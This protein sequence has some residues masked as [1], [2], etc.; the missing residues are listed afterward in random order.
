MTNTRQQS[1][2]YSMCVSVNMCNG[3]GVRSIVSVCVCVCV[4]FF[5]LVFHVYPCVYVCICVSVL[6]VFPIPMF[7]F[8]FYF[9]VSFP[10]CF[11]SSLPVC[12]FLHQSSCVP[13]V[14]N[15]PCLPCVYISLCASLCPCWFI[16][17]MFVVISC[18]FC[19]PCLLSSRP[20]PCC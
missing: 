7:C 1:T 15:C 10:V 14:F 17:M 4:H 18:A 5:L 12:D 3:E 9:V 11:L 20:L 13:P 19:V 2:I 6:K 16:V 8:L